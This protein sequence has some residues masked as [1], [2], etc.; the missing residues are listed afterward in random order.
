MVFELSLVGIWTVFKWSL[1]D[2][3]TVLNDFSADFKLCPINTVFY[4]PLNN[5]WTLDLSSWAVS[6]TTM[7]HCVHWRN[8]RCFDFY[9]SIQMS[10]ICFIWLP[11]T[12]LV[13]SE[14]ASLLCFKFSFGMYQPFVPMLCWICLWE[15]CGFG[16][17]VGILIVM[18][19]L[20]EGT[21]SPEPLYGEGRWVHWRVLRYTFAVQHCEEDTEK[22]T[23]L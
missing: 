22:E 17:F 1:G 16:L 6:L 23:V 7:W 18:F 12:S 21:G 10:T 4:F 8:V 3:L 5:L 19:W 14:R 9:S 13:I 2:G 15:K 11:L 20:A